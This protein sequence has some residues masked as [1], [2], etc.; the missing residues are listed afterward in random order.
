MRYPLTQYVTG[1]LYVFIGKTD[2]R[3]GWCWLG[4]DF[5][6]ERIGGQYLWYWLTLYVSPAMYIP[7]F[8]LHRGIIKP[9]K[10]WYSPKAD[11]M[12]SHPPFVG[13]GH[14]AGHDPASPYPSRRGSKLWYTIL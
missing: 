3:Q 8:L 6:G 11:F 2:A 7:L 5:V 4:N 10:R 14:I 1:I 13:E 9:G 12:I